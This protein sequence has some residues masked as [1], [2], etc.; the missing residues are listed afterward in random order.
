MLKTENLCKVFGGATRDALARLDRDQERD[1]IHEA[2]GSV[3]ALDRVSLAVERGEILVVMGLSGSGKST[4][5][6]CLN[7]LVRPD[8][9]R[10]LFDEGERVIDLAAADAETLRAVRARKI[11]MVFQKHALLPWRTVHENVALGLEFRGMTPREADAIVS[12]KLELVGLSGWR[13]KRPAE[14]SGGM[15]QR[16]GLARALATDADLLLLDEPLSALDPLIRARMQDEILALQRTLQKTMIFVSHDLEEALKLGTRIAIMQ[17]GRV[18]QVGTPAEIVTAPATSYVAE[19]VAHVNPIQVLRGAALMRDVAS[20]ERD[21]ETAG[22]VLLDRDGRWRC[23]LDDE[24]RPQALY[25]GGE[26]GRLVPLSAIA[27]PGQ[28]PANELVTGSPDTPM[29]V[30]V[31]VTHATGRP[32]PLIDAEGKLGGVIGER[33]ILGAILGRAR[34]NP[35]STDPAAS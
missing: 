11:S 19:F 25:V 4:L 34:S 12:D 24:G 23:K 13:D 2:C 31:E 5:L 15:Q 6:R 14:L 20:L 28:V 10:V 32:M 7:C 26:E 8:R 30:A 17:A 35:S 33:E 29:R 18:V 16:V 22:V 9:G 1:A 27:E 3:V 21:P